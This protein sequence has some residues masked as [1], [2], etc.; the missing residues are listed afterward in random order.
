VAKLERPNL[1][2][3]ENTVY[4]F[5][6]KNEGCS[7]NYVRTK[8]TEYPDL[9]IR[10]KIKSLI[11]KSVIEDRKIGSRTH[12]FFVN[13]RTRFA[14]VDKM[15]QK[16]DDQIDS[17]DPL[18]DWLDQMG[19][20]KFPLD[21]QA[22]KWKEVFVFPYIELLATMLGVLYM[23]ESG[24]SKV[25]SQT[26]HDKNVTLFKKLTLQTIAMDNEK[27][28]LD[29]CRKKFHAALDYMSSSPLLNQV[30][31]SIRFKKLIK[32]AEDFEKDFLS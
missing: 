28:V 29:N 20:Q 18:I 19:S 32:M 12:K 31:N 22:Y 11:A 10:R 15:L 3:Y 7:E 9:T 1:D 5:I 8:I 16:I 6:L 25:D 23:K 26:L 14:Q 21:I 27:E 13:D 17:F 2:V 4:E 30:L 24:I